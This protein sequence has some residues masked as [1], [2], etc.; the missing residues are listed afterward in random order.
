MTADNAE[1]R[2]WPNEMVMFV[3][4]LFVTKG[5]HPLRSTWLLRTSGWRDTAA[6]ALALWQLWMDRMGEDPQDVFATQW[7]RDF[8]LS[9]CRTVALSHCR[10]VVLLH[11]MPHSCAVN[12]CA[13][14]ARLLPCILHRCIVASHVALL[15]ATHCVCTF[16]RG[17]KPYR[18]D[19]LEAV[20][21][22]APL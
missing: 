5:D 4:G 22:L 14:Y 11:S 16:V 1:C 19:I 17:D 13:P 18:S 10:T 8:A 21:P 12:R 6:N 9:H 20:N 3:A 15:H 2:R 7:I